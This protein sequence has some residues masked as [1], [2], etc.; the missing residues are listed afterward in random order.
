[1]NR[2]GG[3]DPLLVADIP[4]LGWELLVLAPIELSE[5]PRNHIPVLELRRVRERL[6]E[7]TPHDLETFLG[8]RRSPG[9]FDAP[10]DVPQAIERLAP[11]LS[12][13]LDIIGPGVGRPG[14]IRGGQAD[15]EQAVVGELGRFGQRLGEAELG[16]EAAGGKV[17]LVVKLAGVGDPLVDEDQAGAVIVEELAQRIAGVRRLLVVGC[18]AVERLPAAQLPR[19]LAPEG[20]NDRAV[21]F[22]HRVPRRDLVADQHHQACGPELRCLRF[23]EHG[24]NTGQLPRRR[25]REQVVQGE[26]G[27]GLA[28]PEVGLQLNDGIAASA[29]ETVDCPN[30]QALQTLGEVGPPKELD[31]IPVLVRPFAQVHLPEVGRELGLLVPPARNVLVGCDDLSPRLEAGRGGAFD[32]SARFPAPFP[33]RLL[34]EAYPQQL[35]L[36]PIELVRLRRRNRGEEPA[37][38]V[39]RPIGVVA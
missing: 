32:G 11:A 37:H 25:P 16:L 6:E 33:A 21:I 35:H 19:Q 14:R 22:R 20:S 12:A 9:R 3:L 30:K 39:Q 10:D 23:L 4:T 28:A 38:R 13:D 36:E 26:H 31:R 2:I 15:H 29:S 27:V 17:A 34:V 5:C 18:D 24:V 7:P 8:T 1:M